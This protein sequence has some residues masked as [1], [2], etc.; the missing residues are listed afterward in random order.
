MSL[1]TTNHMVKSFIYPNEFTIKL[2]QKNVKIY[3]KN[4]PTCFSLTTIIRELTV[5]ER[6]NWINKGLDNIKMHGTNVKK[7]PHNV[8]YQKTEFHTHNCRNPQS[9]VF[10]VGFC[11]ASSSVRRVEISEIECVNTSHRYP[12]H[13]EKARGPR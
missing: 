7:K 2:L 5:L 6:F 8:S 13:T 10:I 11:E 3:I 1:P 12:F 9:H 4:A